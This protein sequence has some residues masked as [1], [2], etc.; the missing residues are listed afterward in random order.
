ME[1]DKTW[2]CEN[3]GILKVKRLQHN[4]RCAAAALD[5]WVTKCS[6]QDWH[7]ER[8]ENEYM[9]P[10][11]KLRFEH[12]FYCVWAVG[13]MARQRRDQAIVFLD[14]CSPREICRLEELISWAWFFIGNDFGSL[15]LDTQDETW[16][17]AGDLVASRWGMFHFLTG[18]ILHRSTSLLSLIIPRDISS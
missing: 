10:S 9:R 5:E 1:V 14:K 15:G 7:T 6:I 13:T 12:A 17:A 18:L 3:K 8:G 4:A 16:K 11:E 2:D